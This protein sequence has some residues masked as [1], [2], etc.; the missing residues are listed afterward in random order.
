MGAAPGCG[1]VRAGRAKPAPGRGVRRRFGGERQ[2]P[3][4]PAGHPAVRRSCGGRLC[5][6]VGVAGRTAIAGAV[7]AAATEAAAVLDAGLDALL[8]PGDL[9]VGLF[10]GELPGGDLLVD[11]LGLLLDEEVDQG[12]DVVAGDLGEGL[13]LFLGGL[14]IFDRDAEHIGDRLLLLGPGLGPCFLHG[15]ADG[16]EVVGLLFGDDTVFDQLGDAVLVEA[17]V[18]PVAPATFTLAGVLFDRLFGRIRLD[19]VGVDVL[20]AG[21]ASG[22]EGDGN[23]TE[24]AGADVT[25]ADAK[26]SSTSSP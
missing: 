19:E 10:L 15:G 8:E 20:G 13:T 21:D 3:C 9:L 4:G 24:G 5:C 22:S 11:L 6:S 7:A 1:G 12:V 26:P 18:A 2:G 23:C 14:E 25:V 17:A 16:V